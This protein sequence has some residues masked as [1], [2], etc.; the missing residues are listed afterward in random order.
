MMR[1]RVNE[2][3]VVSAL[4]ALEIAKGVFDVGMLYMKTARYLACFPDAVAFL[5]IAPSVE[6]SNV[7]ILSGFR[8]SKVFMASVEIKTKVAAYA[9][10]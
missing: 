5:D 10:V 4:D 7:E 2:P 6:W 1:G 9:L 8:V 3:A